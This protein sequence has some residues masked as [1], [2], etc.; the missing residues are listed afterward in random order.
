M[1][2][3]R[4]NWIFVL[5]NA[6]A[7]DLVVI[8]NLHASRFCDYLISSTR[9]DDN[10]NAYIVG[11]LCRSMCGGPVR[12]SQVTKLLPSAMWLPALG[13][14]IPHIADHLDKLNVVQFGCPPR[15]GRPSNVNRYT[16]YAKLG[17]FH[18]IPHHE[19]VEQLESYICIFRSSHADEDESQY[20]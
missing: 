16:E 6:S 12:L 3:T 13:S 18:L 20:L 10:A 8:A 9:F 2:T 11:F 7:A 14:S 19:L 5:R 1:S 17:K 4:R 15:Q